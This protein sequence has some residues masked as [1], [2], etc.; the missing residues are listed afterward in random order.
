MFA[1]PTFVYAPCHVGGASRP[2]RALHRVEVACQMGSFD[3]AQEL[4]EQGAEVWP[5][6][7]D[8]DDLLFSR[9]PVTEEKLTAKNIAELLCR[10]EL[11]K[12]KGILQQCHPQV[13]LLQEHQDGPGPVWPSRWG[14]K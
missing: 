3:I 4:L 7:V 1:S 13:C 5:S 11:R 8:V 6:D 14:K 12:C 10:C 9:L 2:S